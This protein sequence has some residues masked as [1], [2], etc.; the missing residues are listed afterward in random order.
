MS[1]VLAHQPAGKDSICKIILFSTPFAG[2]KILSSQKG[3]GLRIRVTLLRI[4]IQLFTLMRIR[5]LLIIKMMRICDY[6]STDPPGL[7]FEPPC[8]HFVRSMALHR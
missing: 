7:H 6:W 8:L 1:A 4:R 3:A 2:S 5:I